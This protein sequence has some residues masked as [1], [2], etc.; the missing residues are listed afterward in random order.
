MDFGGQQEH[1]VEESR[2]LAGCSERIG[3]DTVVFFVVSVTDAD[4]IMT[5]GKSLEHV[6]VTPDKVVLPTAADLAN[7]RDPVLSSAAELLGVKISPADAGKL[8]PYDW[9][10]E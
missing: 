10:A 7:G 6:G 8:F 2:R 1:V 5:D 4:V 3:A 9:P